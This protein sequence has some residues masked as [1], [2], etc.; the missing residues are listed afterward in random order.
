MLR[1]FFLNFISGRLFLIFEGIRM[2]K[3]K[4]LELDFENK[5]IL[6]Y[7]KILLELNMI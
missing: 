4:L 1:N 2:F 7:L 3:K 5:M 6:L